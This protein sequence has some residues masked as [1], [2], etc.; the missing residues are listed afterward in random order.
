VRDWGRPSR[1]H[2]CHGR[3]SSAGRRAIAGGPGGPMA[4]QLGWPVGWRRAAWWAASGW[5]GWG[6]A[7][8]TGWLSLS[9]ARLVGEDWQ[10]PALGP[11]QARTAARNYEMRNALPSYDTNDYTTTPLHHA[12]RQAQVPECRLLWTRIS[13]GIPFLLRQLRNMVPWCG[14]VQCG[15]RV[16]FSPLRVQTPHPAALTDCSHTKQ[17]LVAV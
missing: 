1:Q 16:A 8:R 12:R 13:M 5:R 17:S 14:V 15:L 10:H 4:S 7:A 6:W 3:R 11:G 2:C 9:A